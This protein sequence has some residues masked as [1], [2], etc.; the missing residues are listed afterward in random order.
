MQSSEAVGAQLNKLKWQ[1]NSQSS[2][3]QQEKLDQ[4]ELLHRTFNRTPDLGY[5]RVTRTMIDMTLWETYKTMNHHL[6]VRTSLQMSPCSPPPCVF[7]IVLWF[8]AHSV[9]RQRSSLDKSLLG[10]MPEHTQPQQPQLSPSSSS[11]LQ[12]SSKPGFKKSLKTVKNFRMH[13]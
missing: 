3:C 5:S 11:L 13:I 2:S 1:S 10:S 9:T 6:K 7:G 4:Q 8:Y 12:F